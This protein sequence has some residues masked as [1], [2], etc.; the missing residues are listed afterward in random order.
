MTDMEYQKALN[1]AY[2][3]KQKLEPFCER[4]EI[5]GSIRRM[6]K[7]VKDIE[8][9]CIPEMNT[10]ARRSSGWSTVVF[11]LGNV[12][13]GKIADG[14]YIK[15]W[16]EDESIVLDLFVANPA[17]WAMIYLIRTGS[18]DFSRHILTQF[19]KLG[20]KSESGYPTKDEE[21]LSFDTEED[22][23]RFINMEYVA[24]EDRKI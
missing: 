13:K 6:K 24:P 8:I 23:F 5:A 7:D 22:I 11:M 4:I 9:V 14:K 19:N 20:Y 1:I 10:P 21:K 16:L 17:N 3:I 15:I 2:K 12:L 18:A